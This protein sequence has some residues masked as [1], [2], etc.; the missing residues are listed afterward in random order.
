[1][2]YVGIDH[3][4]K[5]CFG[6]VMNERGEIKFSR[7]FET[8]EEKVRE[9]FGGIGKA[10]VVLEAGRNWAVMYEWLE[11]IFGEVKLAHPQKVKA[12]AEAKIKN[13]KIDSRT[14]AHLLRADLIPEAHVPDRETRGA[15]RVLRQRMFFVRI[16]TMIKNR[17]RILLEGYPEIIEKCPTKGL[18]TDK[19]IE[20]LKKIQLKEKDREILDGDISLLGN[21]RED[22][23]E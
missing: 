9:V 21:K 3:H 1:M 12:I 6:T 7:K 23:E 14:L 10:K 16:Q 17:I 5:Y 22:K 13:D 20:W 11:E 2:L 4:K 15:K 18:F 19:G 8:K